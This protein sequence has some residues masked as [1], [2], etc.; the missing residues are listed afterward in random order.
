MVL[1]PVCYEAG[2]NFR[3]RLNLGLLTAIS[4][5]FLLSV[6]ALGFLE[7]S[8]TFFNFVKTKMINKKKIKIK[9]GNEALQS[10][11]PSQSYQ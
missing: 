7:Y 10:M 1:G 8:A 9:F 4:Y 3:D 2:R 6:F 5:F 11:L